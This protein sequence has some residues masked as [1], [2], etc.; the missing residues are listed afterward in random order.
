M[1]GHARHARD[2]FDANKMGHK[3]PIPLNRNAFGTVVSYSYMLYG[4]NVGK[5]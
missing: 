5:K 3:I 4:E 1:V 2:P